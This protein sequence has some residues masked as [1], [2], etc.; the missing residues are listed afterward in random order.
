VNIRD[1]G[2][3]PRCSSPRWAAPEFGVLAN[4]EAHVASKLR[5]GHLGF[6]DSVSTWPPWVPPGPGVGGYCQGGWVV[7]GVG[8]LIGRVALLDT[9]ATQPNALR[10]RMDTSRW[11]T[12]CSTCRCA[13]PSRARRPRMHAGGMHGH[14]QAPAVT[15]II[16]HP[17]FLMHGGRACA[18]H[19]RRRRA[20]SI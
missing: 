9:C 7:P 2:C 11:V 17:R 1:V 20:R 10:G 12:P 3:G 14:A 5:E 19:A 13:M 8:W 6:R 18:G 15:A 4:I 16:M